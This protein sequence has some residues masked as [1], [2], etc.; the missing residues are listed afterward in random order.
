M[1]VAA[2]GILKADVAPI[3]ISNDVPFPVCDAEDCPT[4]D[5]E[6]QHK[7]ENDSSTSTSTST[8]TTSDDTNDDD[9]LIAAVVVELLSEED[10]LTDS[11]KSLGARR[12]RLRFSTCT[13]REYPRILGD[14]VTVLGP[15]IS[16][17]WEHDEEKV[18]ELEEYEEACK[19][20]RRTQAELKIPS[21]H[22][23]E[24]LTKSGYSRNDIQRAVKKSNIARAQRKRT[25]ETLN[26][27]PLQEAFEKI[28]KAG[29]KPLRR[30]K[31]NKNLM[32]VK[33]NTI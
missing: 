17:S 7:T 8:C 19:D 18:F 30:R 13:I 11:S 23:D 9:E 2:I 10:P 15:P 24:M 26:L 27:Q 29:S 31:S 21:K 6:G 28:L 5:K 33:R 32:K 12:R 1:N 4:F 14:N 22:R 20:T 16:I 3:S 25:V